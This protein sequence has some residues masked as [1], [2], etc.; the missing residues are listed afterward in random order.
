MGQNELRSPI[1][2]AALLLRALTVCLLVVSLPGA[3]AT[4]QEKLGEK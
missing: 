2:K 1:M 4:A 3:P